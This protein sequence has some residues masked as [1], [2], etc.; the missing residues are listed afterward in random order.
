NELKNQYTLNI[1]DNP[2]VSIPESLAHGLSFCRLLF[3]TQRL[4]LKSM[5]VCLL[6][7]SNVPFFMLT[8]RSASRPLSVWKDA[9]AT[10]NDSAAFLIPYVKIA[11]TLIT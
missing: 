2:H 7:S 10:S 8:S 1:Y 11:N 4:S 5:T 9:S 6:C 3:L